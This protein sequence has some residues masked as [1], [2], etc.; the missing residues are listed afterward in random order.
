MYNIF[1]TSTVE[2]DGIGQVL[3]FTKDFTQTD[4][5]WCGFEAVI[6]TPGGKQWGLGAEPGDTPAEI[7]ALACN[8]DYI[9]ATLATLDA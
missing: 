1:A 5:E 3:V 8:P 9:S 6:T 7:H 2:V 4:Y